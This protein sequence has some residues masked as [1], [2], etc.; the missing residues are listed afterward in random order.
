MRRKKLKNQR[1]LVNASRLSGY[2]CHMHV[3]RATRGGLGTFRWFVCNQW[4][5]DINQQRKCNYTE[6]FIDNPIL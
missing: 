1:V 2:T 5:I 4:E 6:A 3:Q